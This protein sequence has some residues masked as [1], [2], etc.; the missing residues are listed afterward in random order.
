MKFFGAEQMIMN[1]TTK[2]NQPKA[3]HGAT[4]WLIGVIT[5]LA[6]L[7][8]LTVKASNERGWAGY[9]RLMREGTNCEAL[10]TRAEPQGNCIAEYSFSI[11]GRNYSGSGP[12]CAAKVGEKVIVTYLVADPSHSCLGHAGERLANDIVTYF[13]GGLSFAPLS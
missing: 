9:L 11:A 1:D 10:I 6:L 3:Q 5:L 8:A 2:E 4:K 7:T 12:D 13:F